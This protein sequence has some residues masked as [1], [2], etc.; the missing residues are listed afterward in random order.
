MSKRTKYSETP[1]RRIYRVTMMCGVVVLKLDKR[2]TCYIEILLAFILLPSP[3]L[4]LTSSGKDREVLVGM[5]T[6]EKF[7]MEAIKVS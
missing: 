6:N 4:F 7:K 5:L 2:Q 3:H 1:R